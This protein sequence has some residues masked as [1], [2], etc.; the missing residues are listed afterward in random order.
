VVSVVDWLVDGIGFVAIDGG[1]IDVIGHYRR[2]WCGNGAVRMQK[3]KKRW[4]GFMGVRVVVLFFMAGGFLQHGFWTGGGGGGGEL[5]ALW[6]RAPRQEKEKA[7]TRPF[8][9]LL[10]K[11]LL[12]TSLP[13]HPRQQPAISHKGK[14]IYAQSFYPRFFH[15]FFTRFDG[16]LL[17]VPLAKHRPFLRTNNGFPK[18]SRGQVCSKI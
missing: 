6:G 4:G 9:Y 8:F 16:C 17:S 11:F 2:G 15:V 14:S 7:P 12:A 5:K 3:E 1:K 18:L 13:R 10:A